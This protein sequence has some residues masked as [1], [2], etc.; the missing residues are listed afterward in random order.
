[1]KLPFQAPVI[2]L[3]RRVSALVISLL[4]SCFMG[5]LNLPQTVQA[6]SFDT[7]RSGGSSS[8]MTD[9]SDSGI[10]VAMT[11]THKELGRCPLKH[12]DVKASVSGYVARVTVLQQFHNPFNEKIEAV[13]TF[14]LAADAAVDEMTMK[15]GS[16][17]IKGSIKKREE[18]RQTYEAARA[19]GNVASLLDQERPNIF[20]QSVANIEPGENIDIEIKYVNLLR[21][22]EGA[23][24]FDF[25]TVVGPRFIPGHRGSGKDGAGTVQN[26]DM[27]PDASRITPPAAH[28]GERAGHDISI[29]MNINAGVPIRSIAS[30]LHEVDIERSGSNTAHLKL[31][32]KNKIPNKDFVATW[33]VAA[34]AVQ[35]GYLTH[36]TGNDG[37]FT[38]ML[39]PPKRVHAASVQPKEMVFLVDCS[40]SQMGLPIRKAKETIDYILKHMNPHDTF[41]IITFN[42][43]VE[44]FPQHPTIAS[45]SMKEQAAAF[46]KTLEAR[47]G[48]W[49][50]PA[51]EAACA[52]PNDAHRLRIV[53]YMTDGYVG[54]DFQIIDTIKKH[55]DRTRWF[56]FGT[57]NSVNRFLIDNIAKE[58][59]GEPDYVLLNSSAE[60]VGK[61][62]Y[63]RISSPVLTDLKIDFAGL[64]TKEVFPKNLSDLWAQ[65]PL[66]FSGRYLKPGKGKVVL[67][68]YSGGKPYKQEMSLDFPA[69]QEANDVLPSI[70]AR[71][72]VERLMSE[73][74]YAM[75]S[76]KLNKELKDEIIDTA[77]KYHIM[78]Q[79]TSFVAVEEDRKT[80][81]SKAR[82]VPVQ[83][84]TP[85]GVQMEAVSGVNRKAR[86]SYGGTTGVHGS[87]TGM[88]GSAGMA[89]SGGMTGSAGMIGSGGMTG[90]ARMRS[91]GGMGLPAT[92]LDSYVQPS[93][94][95]MMPPPP[96]PAVSLSTGDGTG[97][98]TG[99]WNSPYAQGQALRVQAPTAGHYFAGSTGAGAGYSHYAP[100]AFVPGGAA[101]SLPSAG[102]NYYTVP[103][104]T[105]SDSAVRG[106]LMARTGA[107]RESDKMSVGLPTA[108][109]SAYLGNLPESTR[110]I[111][112]DLGH[113][114][115]VVKDYRAAANEQAKKSQ[116]ARSTDKET[117]SQSGSQKFERSLSS[118]LARITR[119]E[120]T[121]RVVN[122]KLMVRV[123]L[124]TVPEESLLD[125]LK[126]LGFELVRRNGK[127]LT[128]R[129]E[130]G[131][132]AELA[133]LAEV[134]KIS[135]P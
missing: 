47:G 22:E 59:G 25:P 91:A 9:C 14:P 106:T 92:T 135:L 94:S 114:L 81:G 50:A 89:G 71:A 100:G 123:E 18:A 93:N 23:F 69:T 125:K 26:T 30:K 86:L 10:L 127:I 126:A 77:L 5:T 75:Q 36:R 74:W 33:S 108:R 96:P 95:A 66:Y 84:E 72:K 113:G 58:G 63:D 133:K 42:N 85:E 3:A 28:E 35:S 121:G 21:Y 46:M 27:V 24:T 119:G 55:R 65:R 32:D 117:A 97:A 53:V 34:D 90:A 54:N 104:S 110:G 56:S 80:E 115:P 99:N 111:A 12:T 131:A 132:L 43:N 120:N 57:G 60:E 118:L 4:L 124:A 107:K 8:S 122:G 62:F 1:M 116:A 37:F 73:D 82:L 67:T 112:S 76:G 13:Y 134:A 103:A 109:T 83:V 78:S 29:E 105:Q 16:R 11:S 79:Y 98:A 45:D 7:G 2:L 70:W 38:L 19:R 51:V 128:G 40:G 88:I 87:A 39:I 130:P 102:N 49:A 64:E 17:I 20:T 129:I 68:G 52:L 44:M 31:K 15:V 6:A 41:Q 101:S 48:T 61:K